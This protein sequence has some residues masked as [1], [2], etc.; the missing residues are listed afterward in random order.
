[1]TMRAT[2]KSPDRLFTPTHGEPA[3]R[4]AVTAVADRVEAIEATLAEW[5]RKAQKE[6]PQKLPLS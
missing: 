2:H 1:M 5:R 4:L 3:H 6:P